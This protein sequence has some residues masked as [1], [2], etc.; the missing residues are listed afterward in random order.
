MEASGVVSC[1]RN[2]AARRVWI[3]QIDGFQDNIVI[4]FDI[5]PKSFVGMWKGTRLN[6]QLSFGN[7]NNP[8]GEVFA[9]TAN[10]HAPCDIETLS[11]VTY[12]QSLVEFV[13]RQEKATDMVASTSLK[14]LNKL[15]KKKGIHESLKTG[16]PPDFAMEFWKQLVTTFDKVCRNYASL[17]I[18]K[19][20]NADLDAY[21]E[22]RGDIS[23]RNTLTKQILDNTSKKISNYS[24]FVANPYLHVNVL[25]QALCVFD[26][27]ASMF[28]L[29]KHEKC[30]GTL[31][32]M[33]KFVSSEDGHTCFPKTKLLDLIFAQS[34]IFNSKS[35]TRYLDECI[36]S[37]DNTFTIFEHGGEEYIYLRYFANMEESIVS[38]I[39]RISSMH[40]SRKI[41]QVQLLIKEYECRKNV[42]L[43][44]HQVEAIHKI[45]NETNMLILVGKA[46]SGKSSVTDCIKYIW[47]QSGGD[48]PIVCAP[49]G[50]AARRID[51]MTIHKILGF[52]GF[53]GGCKYNRETPLETKLIIV[54][55]CSMLDIDL[56]F[57]LFSAIKGG[58]KVVLAGDPGQLPSVGP[59]RI[60]SSLIQSKY[61]P[62]VKLT[63]CFRNGG[64]INH[65]AECVKKGTGDLRLLAQYEDVVIVPVN[66][67]YPE[68]YRDLI[69]EIYTKEK[70]SHAQI[71]VSSKSVGVSAS[72]VNDAIHELM[73]GSYKPFVPGNRVMF[74]KNDSDLDV[75]NGDIG[76]VTKMDGRYCNVDVLGVKSVKIQRDD[77]ELAYGITIHKSQGSEYDVVILV[78]HKSHG[79]L[80][81]KQLLYTAITRAKKKLYIVTSNTTLMRAATTR[82]KQ[83]Y[84]LLEHL[85]HII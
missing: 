10:I 19:C 37:L 2:V 9:I 47:M 23:I 16:V 60:F 21:V 43:H 44:E 82:S 78:L 5:V 55:E 51:G 48:E 63:Q 39:Q 83:R 42:C 58:C 12:I 62:V 49:T 28:H 45:F 74:T 32:Y 41:E 67:D 30:R 80:L 40:E 54:D 84:S 46:G 7:D 57:H 73:F 85:F 4:P 56:A 79:R 72:F 13:T 17:D 18:L 66:D 27:Y 34:S 61:I 22:K 69:R 26:A 33:L 64:N 36:Q 20:L 11:H 81:N 15:A 53:D 24:E 31:I 71:I 3:V 52:N 70:T 38:D 6:C 25:R 1:V 68:E 35:D 75:Y 76:I 59:G 77:I 65:L 14:L 8:F 29:G 50:K